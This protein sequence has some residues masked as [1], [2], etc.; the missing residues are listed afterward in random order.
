LRDEVEMAGERVPAP[1]FKA[2]DD[3]GH[4]R[5]LTDYKGRL[6]VLYFY[7]KDWSIGCI[8]EALEFKRLLREFAERDVAVVGVSRDDVRTH[9]EFKSKL[10][11]PFDLL[12]DPSRRLHEAYGVLRVR[13]VKRR[14]TVAV[15]RSTFVIGRSGDIERVYRNVDP[16]RHPS[17]LFSELLESGLLSGRGKSRY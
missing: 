10:E 7:P 1:R 3:E 8:K 13:M 12:A 9:R 5:T 6:V 11:L 4:A 16:E 14:P 17:A 2:Y 15:S